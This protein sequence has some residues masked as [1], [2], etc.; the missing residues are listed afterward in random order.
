MKNKVPEPIFSPP[1]VV[2]Q[3]QTEKG[4]QELLDLIPQLD[5]ASC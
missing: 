2:N 3:P 4:R 5:E 1:V